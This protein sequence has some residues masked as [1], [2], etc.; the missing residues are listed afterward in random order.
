MA[1]Y[2]YTKPNVTPSSEKKNELSW[3]CMG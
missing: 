2:I 3:V 1:S